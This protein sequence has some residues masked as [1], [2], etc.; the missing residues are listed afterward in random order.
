MLTVLIHY[1][2]GVLILQHCG[3]IRI[4]TF[5]GELWG[6]PFHN[7]R[8]RL[9]ELTYESEAKRGKNRRELKVSD[10][11][12]PLLRW[13][14]SKLPVDSKQVVLALDATYLGER[15][16]ILAVSVVV[17]QTA[18]PVA[19][20]IQC[21]NAKGKW[22]P[23]WKRLLD[24]LQPALP[25]EWTIYALTDSGLRS[26]VL[27]EQLDGY[28]WVPMMRIDASQG[29]FQKAGQHQWVTLRSLVWRGM[30]PRYIRGLCFKGKPIACTIICQWDAQYEHPCLVITSLPVRDIRRGV[31]PIRY[32]IECG[33]KDFK[34]GL[35]HW[36]QTK[37]RCPQ[38]AERLWLVL[39]IALLL[40]TAW[41]DTTPMLAGVTRQQCGL[42]APL[43]GL[44]SWLVALVKHDTDTLPQH[45]R[46]SPYHFPT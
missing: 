7:V 2:Y 25:D 5:L 11:F 12:A 17:S 9:R 4:A 8:Q 35:F 31:Y 23:I 41:G 34:R 20:H 43:F 37:M 40:A 19:W 22:T 45:T 30:S 3:Q 46:F 18:I 16:V 33:F 38:R 29:L 44:I 36:E 26:K 27:F 15:F 39:S 14:L 24:R 1:V 28:K 32:W 13:V 6:E 42:S 21:G 10:C